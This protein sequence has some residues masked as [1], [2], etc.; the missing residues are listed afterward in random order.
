MKEDK[1]AMKNN[2]E[3]II[4]AGQG[5]LSHLTHSP[6]CD[7][8]EVHKYSRFPLSF[9]HPV[10]FKSVLNPTDIRS[11]ITNTYFIDTLSRSSIIM[12]IF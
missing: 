9:Q 2:M 1:S 7:R 4:F 5:S 10:P 3:I 6:S 11:Y 8:F 12:A